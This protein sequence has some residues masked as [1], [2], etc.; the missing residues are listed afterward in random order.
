[1]CKSSNLAFVL[2]F[3]FLFGLEKVRLSLIG[4]IALITV[5]VSR[6]LGGASLRTRA[7]AASQVIMMVAAETE[8]VFEGAVEVLS[9]SACGGLRW[10]LT[11]ILLD[12]EGMGMSN[13]VATIFWL[14]PVM[15][16]SMLS[17]SV[18]IE[19]WPGLFSSKFFG[20]LGE[21]LKTLA[22]VM[23]PGF[24]AFAMNLSEFA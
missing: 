19:D 1:M 6:R 18:M 7:D 10:A 21:S 20:S 12:R 8:F 3:A 23:A 5:G 11:Q 24:V 4:V 2:F 13:P 15:F 14:A 16:V 22:L 9:A 17:V